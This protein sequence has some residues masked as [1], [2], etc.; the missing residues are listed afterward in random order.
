[1]KNLTQQIEDLESKRIK[2]LSINLAGFC[3]WDSLRITTNHLLDI[4]DAPLLTG[5]MLLGWL[6]WIIGLVQIIR[7]SSKVRKTRLALEIMNDELFK[8]N[9]LKAFRTALVTVI[10][11]Q[12]AIIL[13]TTFITHLSGIFVAEISVFISVT[14]V[15]GAFLYFNRDR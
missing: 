7:L 12:L 2:W 1:M 6:I 13:I 4:S 5:I 15:I 8:I 14:T 3:I 11:A 9:L 10:V